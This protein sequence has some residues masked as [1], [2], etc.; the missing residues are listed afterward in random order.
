MADLLDMEYINSLPQPLWDDGWPVHDIEVSSGL[1]RIDVCG[2]LEVR[3]MDRCR[4]MKDATGRHHYTGDFYVDPEMWED[5]F[6]AAQAKK[7]T[8]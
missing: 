5:R 7:E 4:S 1:Y 3:H 8:P 6:H 2:L